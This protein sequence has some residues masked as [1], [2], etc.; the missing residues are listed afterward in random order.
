MLVE[1][2][3]GDAYGMGY[4]YVD[5]NVVKEFNKGYSYRQHPLHHE[6]KPGDYTDDTQMSIAIAEYVLSG[7]DI[8]NERKI[9]DCFVS[10]FKRDP[11]KGYS[12]GFQT[13][14]EEVQSG[15]ELLERIRVNGKTDKNGAAMRS[16]PC[17]LLS[18][19]E[20]VL[21]FTEIQA[22]ITH[23]GTGVLAAKAVAAATWFLRNNKGTVADLPEFLNQTLKVNETWEWT[24][25]V[26]AKEDLGLKTAK[27]AIQAVMLTTDLH[28]LLIESVAYTGDVDT[29]AAIALG[30]ASQ[31]KEH[32]K[33]IPD[34]LLHNL[35]NSKSF[36][37]D[38]LRNLDTEIEEKLCPIQQS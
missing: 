5:P 26:K 25:K 34:S 4:E 36:G 2:A 17:G 3:I 10:C 23:E 27:A 15:K 21:K 11:I 1:I 37:L 6:L 8:E 20:V 16:V 9:T 7:E 32:A 29:V 13:L 28:D 18:D 30:I 33:N 35:R 22:S 38:Y 12:K 19:L 14:L 31:S 24:G